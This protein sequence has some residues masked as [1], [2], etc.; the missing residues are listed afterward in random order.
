[1]R[2]FRQSPLLDLFGLQYPLIQAPMAGANDASMVIAV[3][4]AGAL[5]SL[6]CA[7]LDVKTAE[8]QLQ[9]IRSATNRPFNV[10]FFC[11]QSVQVTSGQ[12]KRWRQ[13]LKPYY[14]EAGLDPEASVAAPSREPFSESMCQLLESFTPEV[15]SFHFGLPDKALV[16]R[17]KAA[18][19]KIISSATTAEEAAWLEKNGC[20]AIIA[21]GVEAGG[22]RGMF[23]TDDISKQTGS[24]ALLPRIVDSVA[25]PV[26]AAGGFA[27]A[28]GIAAA[29]TMGASGVMLGTAYLYTEESLITELHRQ[30]LFE[31]DS[32]STAL[33]NV[34][35]GRPARG[36]TNRVMSEL[37]PISEMTPPFPSA[38]GA[39]APLKSYYEKQGKTDFT[40]L[41][42]GQGHALTRDALVASPLS[43]HLERGVPAAAMTKW[44][45]ERVLSET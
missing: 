41:W 30:A 39:L 23:L 5:G 24:L 27:D 33:T 6:P 34:F 43:A 26:I 4:G 10:N 32:D 19:C 38:G 45:V 36:L 35:S 11:H 2:P 18:G 44:L 1:M 13:A 17:L 9:Q 31:T 29:F 15:V 28:R 12:D 22:H 21:Q 16:V 3:S 20:D 7:M 37:G 42:A 8:A 25:V 14:L 40:S